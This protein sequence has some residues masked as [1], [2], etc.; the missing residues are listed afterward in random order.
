MSVD[1]KLSGWSSHYSGDS[2]RAVRSMFGQTLRQLY[3]VPRQTPHQLQVLLMQLDEGKVDD[4]S[5][6]GE[7]DR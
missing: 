1:A 3:E 4:R 7:A 6:D 2:Y 5:P